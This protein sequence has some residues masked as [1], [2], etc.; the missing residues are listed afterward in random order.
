MLT[1]F[2]YGCE[3]WV[4]NDKNIKTINAFAT[5]GYRKILGI[6]QMIDKISNTEVL[7]RVNSHE[8]IKYVY[9]RQLEKTGHRLR[10]PSTS[11]TN[12]YALYVPTHGRRAPGVT[13]NNF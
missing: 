1:V 4:L 11:L 10:S 6:N 9:K 7:R 2:L 3:T 8:L 13:S 5:V 12:K